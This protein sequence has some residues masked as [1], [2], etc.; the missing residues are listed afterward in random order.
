MDAIRLSH[1]S[2]LK[3]F[4]ILTSKSFIATPNG[5]QGSISISKQWDVENALAFTQEAQELEKKLKVQYRCMP[6]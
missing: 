6:L 2:I 4:Y 5:Y 1:N 3:H